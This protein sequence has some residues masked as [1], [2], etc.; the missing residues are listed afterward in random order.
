MGVTLSKPG[1]SVPMIGV[2]L[3]VGSRLSRSWYLGGVFTWEQSM[4]V[5][6]AGLF[7]TARVG[8]EARYVVN[9]GTASVSINDGPAFPVPRYDWLGLRAGAEAV[10]GWRPTGAFAELA[11]G[12]DAWLANWL[13]LGVV[14]AAGVSVEPRGTYGAAEAVP[15][16]PPP[17]P[18][19]QVVSP[20]F[21]IAFHFGTGA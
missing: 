21:T 20:Y 14:F 6:T 7:Q 15:G 9:Q 5:A 16:G 12:T 8:G 11:F 19:A 3:G 10:G 1:L 4:G 2:D 17:A 13:Q 18:S